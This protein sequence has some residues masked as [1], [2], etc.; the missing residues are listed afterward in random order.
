LVYPSVRKQKNDDVGD[1]DILSHQHLKGFE[2]SV[3]FSDP[4]AIA[5]EGFGNVGHCA[6]AQFRNSIQLAVNT[7]S[8]KLFDS[9]P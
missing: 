7:Q 8:S 3:R 5:F 4:I 1:T 2:G 9:L 6:N